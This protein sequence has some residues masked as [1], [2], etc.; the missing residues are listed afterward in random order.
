ME[1]GIKKEEARKV[2]LSLIHS[3]WNEVGTA[4]QMKAGGRLLEVRC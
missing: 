3:G 2:P 1:K 4:M